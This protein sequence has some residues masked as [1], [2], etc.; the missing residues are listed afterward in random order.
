MS[1]LII[2]I[3]QE[4]ALMSVGPSQQPSGE[5]KQSIRQL[6]WKMM[7]VIMLSPTYEIASFFCFLKQDMDGTCTCTMTRL[8]QV[9]A[10]APVLLHVWASGAWGGKEM[11]GCAIDPRQVI[12]GSDP[13][14]QV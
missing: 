1:E 7:E 5:N 6:K 10:A 9:Q 14:L 13:E 8:F 12:T 3:L 2:D 4:E 11:T